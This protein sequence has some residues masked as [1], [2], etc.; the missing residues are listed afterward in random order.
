MDLLDQYYSK[1]F[2]G[3]EPQAILLSHAHSDHLQM[4]SF[5]KPSIPLYSSLATAIIA[6]ARQDV[7][8]GGVDSETTSIVLKEEWEGLLRSR[9]YRTSPYLCRK[10]MI[11]NDLVTDDVQSFWARSSSSRALQSVPLEVSSG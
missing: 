3:V 11:V 7:S 1:N 6:K 10:Y 9:H 2:H 8:Q 4:V 5:L